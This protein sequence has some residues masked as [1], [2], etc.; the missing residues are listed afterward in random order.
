MEP[1]C[2]TLGDDYL[3]LL[4]E[5]WNLHHLHSLS[6]AVYTQT[7]DVE[8]ECNGLLSYDRAVAKLSPEVL[9]QANAVGRDRT[10]G[11]VVVPDAISADVSWSYTFQW[12]GAD[13]FKPDYS[14]ADWKEGVA[15]FGTPGTPGA[16]VHTIWNTGD[17]WL[18]RPFTLGD[19]DLQ[20]IR[21]EA[22]HDEDLEV[23]LNGVLAA[24]LPG[25]IE[26]Y[27]QFDLQP[28]AVATLKPGVN[29]LAVHCHQTTGGQYVDVGLVLPDEPKTAQHQ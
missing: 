4:R 2:K 10:A 12:P 24:K 3:L 7:T 11:R 18:R 21:M 1:D 16:L 14:A 13:W 8:T 5:V 22:H 23:Y 6:G 15:G 9:A 27:E 26:H 19:E 29:L 20:G 17:I 25:F 28:E